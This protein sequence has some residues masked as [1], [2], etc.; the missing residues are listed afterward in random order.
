MCRSMPYA[1]CHMPHA[2][3]SQLQHVNAQLKH[4]PSSFVVNEDAHTFLMERGYVSPEKLL[5]RNRRAHLIH[6]IYLQYHDS[7]SRVEAEIIKKNVFF[8]VVC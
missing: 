6:T 8:L 7:S 3:L 2:I 5:C 4:S 1:T